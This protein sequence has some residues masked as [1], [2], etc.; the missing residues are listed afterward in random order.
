MATFGF[1]KNKKTPPKT[2]VTDKRVPSVPDAV[3][4]Y[5][6]RPILSEK[7][8]RIKEADNA[9]IFQI[10]DRANKIT[11]AHEVASLYKVHVTKVEIVR[12]PPK[13][14]KT[15]RFSGY[16]SGYRKAIVHV[17]QGEKIELI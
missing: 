6:V 3:Q 1:L 14:K 4:I 12:V 7:A 2:S 17:K 16:R 13:P 8:T 5:L 15:G 10:T 11:V 9:Y